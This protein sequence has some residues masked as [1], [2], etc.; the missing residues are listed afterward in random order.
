MSWET[1]DFGSMIVKRIGEYIERRGLLGREDLH[2]VAV[3]GG[4]DSVCLLLVLRELGFRVEAV[5]CN[6]RLRGAESDRDE[7]FV[8]ELCDRQGVELHLTHFDTR[9]YAELHRV[10]IEMA[11]R[12]LRYRYFEQLRRDIGAATVCVAHHQDDSVETVLMNLLRGTGLRGLQGIQPRRGCIVRPL[13]CVSRREIEQWLAERGQGYVTDSTNMVADVVR[14]KLR[15]DI[16]PRLREVFPQAQANILTTAHFAGEALRVY[17]SA[18]AA[19]LEH[20][21][22]HGSG[23]TGS[24]SERCSIE[25]LLR[26]PSPEAILFEWL[27]PAGFT[28]AAVVQLCSVLPR[29]ESGREWS[30]ATHTLVSHGGFLI[31]EEKD[32]ERRPLLIPEPGTYVY[33]EN[34]KMRIAVTDGPHIERG[35]AMVC[36]ANAR[37]VAFPLTVRR[38]CRGDRFRPLGM[39]GTKLV[40]DFLTDLHLPLTEKR[41]QLAVCDANGDIVWLVGRRMDDAKKVTAYTAATIR[42]TVNC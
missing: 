23:I 6:F 40:S 15:I 16:I 33:D 39:K 38:V 36:C 27:S 41:R 28:S 17:D 21:L 34:T 42:I 9:A 10:S 13:L 37:T 24:V 1:T 25:E 26:E 12:D 11:A 35:N 31:L 14:N 32:E 18:V 8:K 2:L 5:H 20:L 3:S 30:S 22:Q 29:L 4:A 7:V 19:R